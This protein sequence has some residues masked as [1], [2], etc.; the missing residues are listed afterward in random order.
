MT[1]TTGEL[2]ARAKALG[3]KGAGEIEPIACAAYEAHRDAATVPGEYLGSWDEAGA[4]TRRGWRRAVLAALEAL[5]APEP[6]PF[7]V[8]G[9]LAQPG[10]GL[11]PGDVVSMRGVV[12]YVGTAAVDVAFDDDG[13]LR[14][15]PLMLADLT[16]I[17]R[18]APP[19]PDWQP[20]DLA[21]D[22][23]GARYV[24]AAPLGTGASV[25]FCAIA[26]GTRWS[27]DEIPGPLHRL[28]VTRE[29]AP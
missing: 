6:A 10:G 23:R 13:G 26:A 5:P 4:T 3:L 12:K 20:G 22:E 19:E 27:R 24:C 18:P 15:V 14:T 11:K 8:A 25:T 1:G 16:F 21:E 9:A 2:H 7:P 17:E 28:T 29:D